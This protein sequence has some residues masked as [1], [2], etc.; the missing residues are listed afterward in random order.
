MSTNLGTWPRALLSNKAR[1]AAARRV[2][3]GVAGGVV[4]LG[5]LCFL[6]LHLADFKERR[7]A[8]QAVA[9]IV[10]Q[11]KLWPMT[12]ETAEAGK[13]VIWCVDH[14]ARGV[15]YL[16]SRPSQPIVYSNDDAAP[17]TF[18]NAGSHC[19]TVV[20]VVDGRRPQGVVLTFKAEL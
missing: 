10:A 7:A 11:A 19:A 1:L 6:S 12:Y 15:A 16:E 17:L 2:A 8:D 18:G 14:P 9:P 13:P 5:L 3:L 20:A 4:L